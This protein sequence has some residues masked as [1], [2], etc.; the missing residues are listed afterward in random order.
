MR[1]LVTGA[2]GFI[3]HHLVRRLVAMGDEVRCLV[4]PTSKID[5]MRALGVSL[6]EGDVTR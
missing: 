1:A 2:T 5:E 3:G 6:V 4:R